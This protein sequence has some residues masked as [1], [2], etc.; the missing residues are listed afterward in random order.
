[1]ERSEGYLD[2]VLAVGAFIDNYNKA[3]IMLDFFRV[4]QP[5]VSWFTESRCVFGC[6]SWR[7]SACTHVRP[8]SEQV[9]FRGRLDEVQIYPRAL[10]AREAALLNAVSTTQGCRPQALSGSGGRFHQLKGAATLH[11]V[12]GVQPLSPS[13]SWLQWVS[14]RMFQGVHI[15]GVAEESCYGCQC[16]RM[17]SQMLGLG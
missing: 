4:S 11:E 10:I 2:S 5:E 1:M 16:H 17:T 7:L 8:P 6:V 9:H 3:P 15:N 13:V 12:C 14:L